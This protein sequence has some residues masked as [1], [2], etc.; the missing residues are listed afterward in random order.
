MDLLWAMQVY[1]KVVEAASFSGAARQLDL[2]NAS[3]TSCIRNLESHLGVTLLQRTTRHLHVTDEGAAYYDR[4]KA[5]LGQVEEAESS[6]RGA[7]EGLRG[8]LRIEAPFAIG[9]SVLAPVLVDFAARN[10]ELRIVTTLTNQVDNLVERGIDLAIRMDEVEGGDLVAKPIYEG[11]YVVCA[12]PA[13]LKK[14][15]A[16]ASPQELKAAL[17]L[18]LTGHSSTTARP[19]SFRRGAEEY[20]LWPEGNLSFNAT[21]ALMRAA[22]LGAGLVYVLDILVRDFINRGELVQVLPEWQTAKRTFYLVYPKSRFIAPKV[23]A[24]AEFISS[25]LAA[26]A[27]DPRRPVRIRPGGK[28]QRAP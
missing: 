21:D 2:A 27:A 12:S 9:H 3:V 19:W 4:C 25:A 7:R 6:A 26:P 15:G 13:F 8:T 11:D 14:A 28:R 22:T 16:P 10:P 18:G 17:C 5:I 1:V 23:K 20:R 24:F